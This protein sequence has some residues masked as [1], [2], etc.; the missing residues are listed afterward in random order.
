[1]S[2][3]IKCDNCSIDSGI[4]KSSSDGTDA[5][6]L[7]RINWVVKCPMLV[8]I[9]D[10]FFTCSDQCMKVVLENAYTEKG[11]TEEDKA[12]AK[13]ITDDFKARIPEMAKQTAEAAT[14]FQSVLRGIKR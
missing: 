2:E 4:L 14:R 12:A 13:V 1:M 10:W 8:G 9:A 3:T 7:V 11:V 5:A 6:R